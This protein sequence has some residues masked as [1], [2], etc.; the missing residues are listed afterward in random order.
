MKSTSAVSALALLAALGLAPSEG[1]AQAAAEPTAAAPAT[2][3]EPKVQHIVIEDDN[4]R[5]E[6]LRVRG[7]SQRIVVQSKVA[8]ARPYEIRPA[9]PGRD[10][11]QPLQDRRSSGQS[12]WQVLSF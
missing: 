8:G 2:R 5:I 4:V 10:P 3:V 1:R 7:Q 6:E 11:S 12:V 9:D